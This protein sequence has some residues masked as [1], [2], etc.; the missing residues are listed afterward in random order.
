MRLGLVGDEA[1]I[2]G[3]VGLDR[4]D[5][6]AGD[7]VAQGRRKGLGRDQRALQR[8][9]VGAELAALVEDDAQ[10]RGRADISRRLEVDDRLHLLLGL[11]GAAGDDGAAERVRAGLHH[12]AGRRQMVGEA[13]VQHVAGAEAGGEQRARHA[14]VIGATPLGV[15]DRA[16][17]HEEARELARRPR[18]EAAEGRRLF[19]QRDELA[20]A[21]HRQLGQRLAIGHRVRLDILQQSGEIGRVTLGVRHLLRQ[22]RHQRQLARFG[23]AGFECVVDSE[24]RWR[25]IECDPARL[26]DPGL[27]RA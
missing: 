16:G 14:P 7:L 11:A 19:L 8:R 17:R 12:R 1:E 9:E 23:V 6:V 26:S 18:G 10:E 24:H 27:I 3:A 22:R 15:I 20:L 25:D 4:G 2:G 13:I 21:R 5:A